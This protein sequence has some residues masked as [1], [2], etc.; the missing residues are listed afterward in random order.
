[1]NNHNEDIPSVETEETKPDS[2]HEA[3]C[4]MIR[5]S[6]ALDWKKLAEMQV[7]NSD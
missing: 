6:E 3:I 2:K 7:S 1:M 4:E 5:H